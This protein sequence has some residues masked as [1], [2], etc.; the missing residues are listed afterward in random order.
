MQWANAGFG[1]HSRIVFP[2]MNQVNL[3][4]REPKGVDFQHFCQS[5]KN[6]GGDALSSH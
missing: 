5:G 6:G 2:V 3:G 1:A 4:L